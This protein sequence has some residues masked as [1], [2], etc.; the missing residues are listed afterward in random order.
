MRVEIAFGNGFNRKGHE[1]FPAC[2]MQAQRS[3][4]VQSVNHAFYSSFESKDIEID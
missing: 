1:V 4:S 3:L 2:G